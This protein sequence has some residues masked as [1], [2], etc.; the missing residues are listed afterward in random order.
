M[1]RRV[2]V[3]SPYAARSAWWLLAL[4]ERRANR[5]YAR[6]AMHDCLSRGEAP[7][8]T[9]LL[10]TQPGVLSDGDP[11]ERQLGIAAGLAW[12]AVAEAS[13]VYLDRGI[14][15]GMEQAIAVAKATGVAVEYRSLYPTKKPRAWR[16]LVV[17]DEE[18]GPSARPPG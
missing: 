17:A 14:S 16:G 9:H 18:D 6:R 12:Q 10:Y 15:L 7:I 3:E 5:T 2:I 11:K 4:L 1:V 8:A 13:V